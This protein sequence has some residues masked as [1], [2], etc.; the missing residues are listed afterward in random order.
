MAHGAHLPQ[1]GGGLASER[2]C[3]TT[4]NGDADIQRDPIPEGCSFVGAPMPYWLRLT[5]DGVGHHIGKVPRYPASHAC[6]RGPR[7]VMPT[8][9]GKVKVGTPVIVQG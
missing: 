3:G 9:Y 1:G 5:W 2:G 4:V 6:I 8:V 7:G